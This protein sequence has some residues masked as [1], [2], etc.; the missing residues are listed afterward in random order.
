MLRECG[1]DASALIAEIGLRAETFDHPDNVIPFAKLAE[2]AHLAAERTGLPDL[3]LRNCITT[4]LAVLGTIGHLVANSA[5]VGGGLTSFVSYLHLHDEG[6]A[7]FIKQEGR[8]AIMGY[9]V[10]EPDLPGTEQI[11]FGALVVITNL[12]REICG[13]SFALR[14]VDFAYRAPEDTSAFV[15]YFATPVRFDADRNAVVFD[16]KW[17]GQPIANANTQL[18]QFFALHVRDNK[19][20]GEGGAVKDQSQRIM[21]TLLSTGCIDQDEVARAFGMS[22]RTFARRLEENGTTFRELLDAARFDAARGLLRSS[23]ASL[24]DIANRLCYSDAT[25]FAR[26]FRRWSG[27]SP[28]AWRRNHGV[29]A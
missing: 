15:A 21:R 7:P 8:L 26:A 17:L 18:H 9:E 24:E 5:T 12:L 3:G 19:V 22:R 20:V 6:A 11:V 2:L 14:E 16:A 25:A 4:G 10:L 23:G 1:I 28:A 13:A 27:E 29:L